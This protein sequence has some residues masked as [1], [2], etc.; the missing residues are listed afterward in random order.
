MT[1]KI[2]AKVAHQSDITKSTVDDPAASKAEIQWVIGAD[3]NAPN[4]Y[5]RRF[6]VQKDGYSPKHS[7]PYEHEVYCLAGNG[8]IL[9]DDKWH[10]FEKDYVIFVPPDVIHQF[11][12]IGDSELIFLCAIPANAKK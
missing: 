2:S 9:I 12:N 10:D 1:E 4:F 8:K 7:H 3:D 11:K 6:T 5:L